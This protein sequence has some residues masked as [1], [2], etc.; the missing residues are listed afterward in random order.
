M[1]KVRRTAL[2]ASLLLITA[3]ACGSGDSPTTAAAPSTT[4]E[5]TLPPTTAAAKPS[6]VLDNA[7]A[8][9]RQPLV[10]RLA[11]GSTSKSAMV[12]QLTLKITIDGQ[13]APTGVVPGTKMVMED[14]VDRVD[15]DGKAHL[16]T[17]FVDVSTVA[18]PG[19]DPEVVRG[20][21]AAINSIKGLRSTRT[22]D[23]Q[24]NVSNVSLDS[25]GVTDPAIKNTLDSMTSQIG[26]LSTPFPAEPV[27]IGARWTVKG[28]A[29]ITGLQMT[30]TTRYT[31]KSRTGDRYELDMA[32]DAVAT[33]GP[34]PLPN[35]PAGATASV[36]SFSMRNTGQISGDLTRHTPVNSSNKGTGDANFEMSVGTQKARL[37]QQMTI[38]ITVSPA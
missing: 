36:T 26:N 5:S 38:E 24:G 33:P 7:G 27:G 30:T 13:A 4:T 35:L 12:N 31:L 14:K 9:P 25:R 37:V 17:T 20:T 19:A 10:L 32:S 11:P 3:V 15:A 1:H 28:T 21:Q 6:V 2:A 22:V 16:S 18:T 23:A 8:Q 34:A 29:V